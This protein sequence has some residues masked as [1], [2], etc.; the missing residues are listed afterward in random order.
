MKTLTVFTP[1]FNRAY[2]L[3]KCYESLKRQTSKDFIWLIVDDGS[4]DNTKELVDKWVKENLVEIKYYYQEN[5]GMHGSHNTAYQHINTE[6]NTCIDSDDY[7]PNDAV[8]KIVSFWKKNKREGIAGIMALDS[9]TN[10]QIIGDKFPDNTKESTYFDI[11]NK[12]GLKGDKKLIYRSDLT[13]MYP[14]PI[15]EGEKYVSLAY[16]Y[17]KLDENY[18]LLLMN[19]VVCNV[20]YMEDGSS[21]NMINQYRKNPK[22]FA[23]IRIDNLNNPKA[24]L[25]FK[26]KECIH[27][28]SS[29]LISKNK[30]FLIE[31]PCKLLTILA[32]PFGMIMYF[33]IMK[34]TAE[35]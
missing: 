17:A 30:R 16:K 2:I 25:K 9:Y 7:M 24:T 35:V 19:E 20:E 1:T 5:Q 3:N 21:L 13:K 32:I 23:F 27:Y 11:Y 8:E 6:I 10:G 18:K 34:K 15:F 4:T 31:T 28:V 29:S 22:G 12:Y 33:Y 14:Y 26:F